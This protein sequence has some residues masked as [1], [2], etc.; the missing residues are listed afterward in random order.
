MGK[1]VAEWARVRPQEQPRDLDRKT[2]ESVQFLF[3]YRGSR[4]STDYI[5]EALIPLLCRCAG[6][7][8]EDSRGAITSHR[9]RATIASMLYNARE[10]L[11]IYDVKSQ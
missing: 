9:A 1:R 3:S 2:S 4:I 5:N 11:S 8:E 10:P 7:P 6:V